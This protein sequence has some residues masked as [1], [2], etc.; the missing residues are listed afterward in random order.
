MTKDIHHDITNLSR[1][2]RV[3]DVIVL[4]NDKVSVR[5]IATRTTESYL[6]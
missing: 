6:S 1:S 4:V 3:G 2:L 5:E